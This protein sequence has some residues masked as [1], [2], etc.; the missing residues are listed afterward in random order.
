MGT[1]SSAASSPLSMASRPSPVTAVVANPAWT[2]V[3]VRKGG[4]KVEQVQYYHRAVGCQIVTGPVKTFVALEWL[5]PGE[6]EDT[7]ALRLLRKIPAGTWS[8]A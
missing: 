5:K 6:G 7:A 8:S 3:W 2:R 4:V 1:A